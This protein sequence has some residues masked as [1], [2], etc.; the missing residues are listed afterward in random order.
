MPF[1]ELFNCLFEVENEVI[2]V[3]C[4]LLDDIYGKTRQSDPF[5]PILVDQVNALIF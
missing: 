3:V 4:I 5:G 1:I 2:V